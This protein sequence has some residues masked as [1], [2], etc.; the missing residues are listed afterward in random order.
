MTLKYISLP[1]FL[2]STLNSNY[3]KDKKSKHEITYKDVFKS[4]LQ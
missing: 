2:D 3:L 1:S 4:Y